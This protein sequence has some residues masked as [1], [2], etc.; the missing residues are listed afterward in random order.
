MTAAGARANR[1]LL[2]RRH[3]AGHPRQE[4]DQA[5]ARYTAMMTIAAINIWLRTDF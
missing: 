3:I 1:R 4:L 5:A 2:C